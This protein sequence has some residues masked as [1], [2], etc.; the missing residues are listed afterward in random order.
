MALG[1][2]RHGRPYRTVVLLSDGEIDSGATWEAILLAA[3]HKLDNL[4]AIVDRN[5]QQALGPTEEIIPLENL[6][7]KWEA[8][9]WE[10]RT[11]DGHNYREIL[12]TLN[13]VPFALNKPS[14]IIAETIKGKGVSFMEDKVEWHY[15]SP[16]SEQ[17]DLAMKELKDCK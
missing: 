5:G 16:N 4:L 12:D 9:G 8:F 11:I 2:K 3:G 13:K 14:V 15:K 10:A 6:A 7:A 1:G 17:Y